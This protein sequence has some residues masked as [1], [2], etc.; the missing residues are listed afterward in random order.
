M[1]GLGGRFLAR[2]CDLVCPFFTQD[3]VPVYLRADTQKSI[4]QFIQL[5]I[6]FGAFV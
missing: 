1:I 2:A 5:F 3:R 4:G 6:I